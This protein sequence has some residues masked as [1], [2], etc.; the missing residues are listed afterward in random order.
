MS[1]SLP[2][3]EVGACTDVGRVR[4]ENQDA[5]AVF[6]FGGGADGPALFLVAD[7]MGGEA[8]GARASRIASER[9]ASTFFAGEGS[10]KENLHEAVAVANAAVYEATQNGQRMGTTCTAIAV[11]PSDTGAQ[12]MLAHVGDSQA[13]RVGPHGEA[14]MLTRD[15]TVANE[16]VASGILTSDEAARHPR[17]HAL[18]RSMGT[19]PA[20]EPDVLP[21][22]PAAP[23]VRF[24]LCS[25][26][27][28]EVA[29][30]E[31]AETVRQHGAQD[32]AERLVALA[33]DRGGRDNVTVVV[34][35]VL[36]A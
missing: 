5:H 20:V 16:M 36:D 23:G 29:P 19:M 34:V 9:F 2:S 27:L 10:V 35:H 1:V 13:F 33:N 24:V 25:D 3:F 31:I 28:A 11:Y 17:R 30:D 32:A 26:G 22:G 6:P 14:R 8:D 21:V 12:V 15:H 18:T 7:G 4:L